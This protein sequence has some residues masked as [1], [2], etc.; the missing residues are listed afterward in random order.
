VEGDG[1]RKEAALPDDPEISEQMWIDA[2]REH[3]QGEII[4]ARDLL[5]V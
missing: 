3:F 4:V 5:E 2:A 1:E